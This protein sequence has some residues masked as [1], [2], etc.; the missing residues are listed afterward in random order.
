MPEVIIYSSDNC[1]YC[2]MAKQLLASKG[3]DYTEIRV[4]IDVDQR[5]IMM[6]KSGQRTVPQIFIN[7][8]HVGGF[9]DLK[10]LEDAGKLDSL[11][12]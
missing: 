5:Q 3:A 12:K 10:A 1:G 9:D 8:Q 2:Q 6:D 7:D 4:D 11:L